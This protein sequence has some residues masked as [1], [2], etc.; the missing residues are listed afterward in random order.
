[1]GW[2]SYQEDNL[3]ARGEAVAIDKAGKSFTK[4]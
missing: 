3:D 2:G 1:M 4:A